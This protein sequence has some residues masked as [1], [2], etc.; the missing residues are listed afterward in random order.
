[1]QRKDYPMNWKRIAFASLMAAA[2]LATVF[3]LSRR[4]QAQATNQL[5]GTYRLVSLKLTLSSTGETIDVMGK[6]P[7]GYIIYGRDGRMMV[8]YVNDERPNPKNLQAVTDQERVDLFKTMNAYSGRYDFDGKVV[9]HHID[10][11]G[12]QT[13]T[14]TDQVRNVKFDGRKVILTTNPQVTSFGGKVGV[15]VN[16]WEKVD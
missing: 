13:W 8:L 15:V 2:V 1:M 10:V 3:G 16:T 11:S 7:K 4:S 6:A 9:T 12:N 14:G 5:A